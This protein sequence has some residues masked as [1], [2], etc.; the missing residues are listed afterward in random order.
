MKIKMIVSWIII[1]II[2]ISIIIII[3]II[4]LLPVCY[5]GV[6]SRA[7]HGS[8]SLRNVLRSI[9]FPWECQIDLT[10]LPPLKWKKF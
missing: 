7:F 1:T 2:I 3:T 9:L 8:I 10:E 5:A 4:L 6:Q